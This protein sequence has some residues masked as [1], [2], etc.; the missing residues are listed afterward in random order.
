MRSLRNSLLLV[1]TA[2]VTLTPA[3]LAQA[4]TILSTESAPTPVAAWDGVVMWSQKDA[5]TGRYRLVK[6]VDGGRG[7]RLV[8]YR[9][10]GSKLSYGRGSSRWIST[11]WAGPEHGVATASSLHDGETAGACEDAGVQYCHVALT[12][13]VSFTPAP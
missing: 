4:P 8:R 5:A 10:R 12:G 2:A 3:A 1:A 6:S 7:N 11:A 9:L 13:P